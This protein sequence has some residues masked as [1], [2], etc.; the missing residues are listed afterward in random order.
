MERLLMRV[1]YPILEAPVLAHALLVAACVWAR[2]D[3]GRL[4]CD[5][6]ARFVKEVLALYSSNRL[7]GF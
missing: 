5:S 3:R 1:H 4:I 6:E 2:L 7:C